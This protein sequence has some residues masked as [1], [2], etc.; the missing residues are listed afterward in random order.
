MLASFGLSCLKRAMKARGAEEVS[1]E[2]TVERFDPFVPL[3]LSSFKTYHNPI[4]MSSLT[5]IQEMLQLNLPSFSSLLRKFLN[6]IFK[7]FSSTE[8]EDTDLINILFRCTS[9]LIRTSSAYQDL[10]DQQLAT[11]MEIIKTHVS[12]FA[13]QSNALNC[14]RSVVHRRF[15]C[16][17]LYD[18]M[19]QVQQMMVH[20]TSPNIR[21]LCSGI[22]IQFLI[23]YPLAAKRVESHIHFVIQN[24]ECKITDVR[25]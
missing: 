20:N 7:L 13:V 9:E 18:L 22:F 4:V 15:E 16:A 3:I 5:I 21:G 23:D 1:K 11:L 10:S 12:K 25:L 2:E 6:R 14:L 19:E 8:S 17:A 24:L